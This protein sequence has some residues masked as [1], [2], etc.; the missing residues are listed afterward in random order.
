[1]NISFT[2]DEKKDIYRFTGWF[3]NCIKTGI[4]KTCGL[5]N[6]RLNALFIEINPTTMTIYSFFALELYHILDSLIKQRGGKY[7]MYGIDVTSIQD[8]KR[9]IQMNTWYEGPKSGVEEHGYD[10]HSLKYK[11]KFPPLPQHHE[12]YKKHKYMVDHIGYRGSLLGLDAGLA[13]TYGAL[14]LTEFHGADRILCIVPKKAMFTVW[15]DSLV[16]ELY[17]SPQSYYIV[18]PRE[19]HPVYANGNKQYN[20]EKFIICHYEAM[21][22]LK[23]SKLIKRIKTGKHALIVDEIHNFNGLTSKRTKALLDITRE[24]NSNCVSLLSGTPVTS[25]SLDMNVMVALLDRHSNAVILKRFTALYGGNVSKYTKDMTNERYGLYSTTIKKSSKNMVSKVSVKTVDIK[26][27]NTRP[28]ELATIRVAMKDYTRKRTDELVGRT[29]ESFTELEELLVANGITQIDTTNVEAIHARTITVTEY[30]AVVRKVRDIHDN[31][32]L[33]EASVIIT[34]S[35]QIERSIASKLDGDVKKRFRELKTICKYPMLKAIGEALGRILLR[36]R[37]DCFTDIAKVIKYKDVINSTLKKTIVF[38]SYVNVAEAVRNGVTVLGYK[39]RYAYGEHTGRLTSNINEFK[40]DKSINPL[41]ATFKSL[42][43][44]VPLVEANTILMVDVPFRSK[45]YDQAVARVWRT[46][47]D[48][49][50]TVY[51]MNL[52]SKEPTINDRNIDILKFYRDVVSEITGVESTIPITEEENVAIAT[53]SVGHNENYLPR[54]N[55]FN[56]IVDD[57]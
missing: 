53:E 40:D 38:T 22:K 32:N 29:T 44:A 31:G 43:E 35:N 34:K 36:T 25:S 9:L 20:G 4:T 56:T 18:D 2:H 1:M 24:Y 15:I 21:D 7:S 45:D 41:I 13:K 27:K 49:D 42:G 26:L 57:W 17:K 5:S 39:P 8:V 55:R 52:V 37:I 12:V 23:R 54:I 16:N 46:G 48:S 11:F 3:G 19:G 14:T 28:Y 50:V 30:L 47:Q 6:K 10:V 51:T 33:R